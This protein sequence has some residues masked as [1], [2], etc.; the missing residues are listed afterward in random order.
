MRP[1]ALFPTCLLHSWGQS[2]K[3]LNILINEKRTWQEQIKFS[4]VFWFIRV[5]GLRFCV[6]CPTVQ[7]MPLLLQSRGQVFKG[8]ERNPKCNEFLPTSQVSF[9]VPEIHL[10]LCVQQWEHIPSWDFPELDSLLLALLSG[11][12]KTYQKTVQWFKLKIAQ[13]MEKK[14]Y[15]SNT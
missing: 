4:W 9:L 5:D 12:W 15:N 10:P 6:V 3:L 13:S 14:Q 1:A 2:T 11:V 7:F 8:P